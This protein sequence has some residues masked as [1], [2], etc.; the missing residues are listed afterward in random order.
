MTLHLFTLVLGG[1]TTFVGTQKTSGGRK[2]WTSCPRHMVDFAQCWRTFS[3][4][5]GIRSLTTQSCTT[6]GGVG[7]RCL[8]SRQFSG[9]RRLP[10]FEGPRPA[11]LPN[12]GLGFA[13]P[14]RGG[15]GWPKRGR[16]PVWL[17]LPT[18]KGEA[19]AGGLGCWRLG[20][21][22]IAILP[23]CPIAYMAH[24]AHIALIATFLVSLG[25]ASAYGPVQ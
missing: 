2:T 19:A 10:T 4:T 18:R 9:P 8:C 16:M 7:G 6:A 23:H 15:G 17:P 20:H 5:S 3:L 11:P 25:T 24:I 12:D 1:P 21:G 22:H 13:R 14:S